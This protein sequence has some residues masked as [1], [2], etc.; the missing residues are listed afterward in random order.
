MPFLLSGVLQDKSFG[1]G[2]FCFVKKI[3]TL[4]KPSGPNT[5]KTEWLLGLRGRML[6]GGLAVNHDRGKLGLARSGKQII[7]CAMGLLSQ[8]MHDGLK[9]LV[10]S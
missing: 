3:G 8:Q 4:S 7:K 6:L 1:L 10:V 9:A 5:H 2:F